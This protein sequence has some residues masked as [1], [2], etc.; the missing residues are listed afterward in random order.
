MRIDDDS[1]ADRAQ[2][3]RAQ[4]RKTQEQ[5]QKRRTDEVTT[6]DKKLQSNKEQ[7]SFAAQLNQ[8][9][10][11]KS[12][13]DLIKSLLASK[14]DL[15]EH[16]EVREEG[17]AP[18]HAETES[19]A[20]AQ[21]FAD[22]TSDQQALA[23]NAA[24]GKEIDR[25]TGR[26]VAEGRGDDAHVDAGYAEAAQSGQAE[27]D[28]RAVSRKSDART[29]DGREQGRDDRQAPGEKGGRTGSRQ[30]G[31]RKGEQRGGQQQGGGSQQNP[32]PGAFRLPPAALMAPP[33]VAVP[34]GEGQVSRLRE[35]AKEIAEK[36]V[37][38]ARVGT[39]K[40]GLPEFQ[41]ELKSE[42]LKGL[43]VKVSGRHGRIRALF[44]SRD[45]AVLKQLRGEVENLR[46]ALTARGLKVDA[47][48]IEE[49]RT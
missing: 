22:T 29:D 16:G 47:L 3:A 26:Q 43:K 41:I 12:A 44:K 23:R 37:Q 10:Q 7:G 45:L 40:M 31:E 27:G 15:P 49:E 5:Q 14:P 18:K 33:P 4:E 20:D 13:K 9:Q 34:K 21:R 46:A 1:A 6:F 28:S 19:A 8:G 24:G 11:Q 36:I 25:K 35:V 2:D 38:H 30:V 42:I 17:T 39:N 32:S 48:E